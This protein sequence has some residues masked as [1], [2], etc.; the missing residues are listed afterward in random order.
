VRVL[1]DATDAG[2]VESDAIAAA[3]CGPER[4]ERGQ[5]YLRENIRYSWS[6]RETAGLRAYYALAHKHGLVEDVRDPVFYSAR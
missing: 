6:A 2:V 3:Y 4:A 5:R 1:V